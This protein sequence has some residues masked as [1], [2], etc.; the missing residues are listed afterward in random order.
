MKKQHFLWITVLVGMLLWMPV[1]PVHAQAAKITFTQ[2][3]DKI[4][5]G[6]TFTFQAATD[7]NSPV[8]YSVTDESLATITEDGQLTAKKAGSVKVIAQ[9]ADISASTNVNIIG[10]KIVCL[11]PG[12]SAKMS[13]GTEPIGPGASTRKAKDAVGTRGVVSGTY[14]YQFTLTLAKR[15]QTLLEK[16][17]YEVIL[18]RKDSKHAISCKERA[19]VANDAD[20]DIFVRLHVDASASGSARG[21]SALYPSSANPYNGKLSKKCKK[22]SKCILNNMCEEAGTHNR[23]LFVRNDLSGS[24]WAA[25]PVTLIEVGFMT[26]AT[27]DRLL[28]KT[29][30]QKK[31]AKGIVSGI[32]EYFGY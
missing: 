20:A 5:A 29:S 12:H 25:M 11:D 26:N 6:N 13:G 8:T 17:G 32:D 16:K 4:K 23:G 24:N 15:L 28:N 31:L 9:S 27:E 30:Y 19:M 18:T 10:K 7:D 3:K 21:A 14:E 22:L 1:M 2:T